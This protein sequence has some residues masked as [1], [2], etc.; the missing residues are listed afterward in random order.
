VKLL[1]CM[2]TEKKVEAIKQALLDEGVNGMTISPVKGFGIHRSQVEQKISKNYLVEFSPRVMLEI[3]LPDHK[4]E[5][6]I[7]RISE[8][9]RTGRLGDGKLFVLPVEDAVR[10]R[11]GERGNTVL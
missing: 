3:V 4:V 1:K 11:T 7:K 5:S 10:L 8:L 9:A 2:V 6:A